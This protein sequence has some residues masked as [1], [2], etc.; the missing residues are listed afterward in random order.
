[1]AL[2]GFAG[3]VALVWFN[4]LPAEPNNLDNFQQQPYLFPLFPLAIAIALVGLAHSRWVGR[5]VDNRFARYTATISFGLYIWHYLVLYLLSYITEGR[6]EYFGIVSWGQ[7]LAIGAVLLAISYGIAT[8]SWRW[9][10]KPALTSRWAN[11]R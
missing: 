1:V 8:L 2:A 3:A 9:I 11:R 4:R 10:E 6:F 7:H 5:V